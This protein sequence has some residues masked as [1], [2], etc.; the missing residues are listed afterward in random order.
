MIEITR[1]HWFSIDSGRCLHRTN[2]ASSFKAWCCK[3][4]LDTEVDYSW[5]QEAAEI[6]EKYREAMKK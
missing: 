2:S 3:Q 1:C 5:Y 4:K 6:C